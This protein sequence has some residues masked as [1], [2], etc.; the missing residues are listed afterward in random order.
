MRVM[1]TSLDEVLVLECKEKRDNRGFYTVTYSEEEYAEGGIEFH[2]V[3]ERTYH[4]E[5][6]GTLF[7]IHF[8]NQPMAQAKIL[9]C[10]NGSGWDYAVDLRKNSPTYKKWTCVDLNGSIGRQI[11]IPKGFG[12]A[13]LSK[14]DNTCIVMRIDEYFDE[15]YSRQ[16][17]WN[18]EELAIPFPVVEPIL[19]QHD[20]VA[21]RLWESDCNL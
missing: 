21:P 17:A 10:T 9:Y 2:C 18:D 6:A 7:G 16:I 20:V 5:K 8:Q 13:F 3:E 12:H 14:E 19:A 4:V 15:R 11:Y 1:K